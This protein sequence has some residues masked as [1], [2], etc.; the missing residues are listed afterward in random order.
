MRNPDSSLHAGQVGHVEGDFQTSS[1]GKVL[2]GTHGEVNQGFSRVYGEYQATMPAI[3]RSEPVRRMVDAP[4]KV[5]RDAPN[6]LAHDTACH[7]VISPPPTPEPKLERGLRVKVWKGANKITLNRVTD[8]CEIKDEKEKPKK[9]GKITDCTWASMR[10]LK[11]DLAEVERQTIAFTSCFTYPSQIK[12]LCPNA[13]ES[14]AQFLIMC[15]WMNKHLPWLPIYW[16]REPQ[17][18]GIT[19]YHLLYFQLD[20]VTEEQLKAAILLIMRKWCRLTTGTGSGFP[21]CEHEKQ[22]SWHTH[23][24]NFQAVKKGDSFFNYLGKY[25]SKDSGE[26]PEGYCN[27]GGGR[28]WGKVNGDMIPRVEA[29]DKTLRL[30]DQ[31]EKQCMRIAYKL[32]DQR[33]QNSYDGLHH[34]AENPRQ[35]REWLHRAIFTNGQFGELPRAKAYIAARKMATHMMFKMEGARRAASA[36]IKVKENWH[37]GS[38]T[39]LG[40]PDKIAAYLQ[41]FLTGKPDLAARKRIFGDCYVVPSR[42][43]EEN[44]QESSRR[45]APSA[46]GIEART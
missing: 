1:A 45:N 21:L 37:F 19:H 4:G 27:E 13:A 25:L 35:Q 14:K 41:R 30:G 43:I 36:P 20:G 39:F 22:L 9:R 31:K 5:R 34:V 44:Q 15:K 18:N 3:T 33:K 42:V 12:E 6:A 38:C 29:T 24:K 46:Q 11:S 7:S 23:D 40:N 2:F 16:K 8:T 17:K 10:R 28:W 26:I 32:R